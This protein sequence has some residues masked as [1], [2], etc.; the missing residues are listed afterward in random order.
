MRLAA[1][2]EAAS[3]A[4]AAAT[5]VTEL[6]EPNR[7][8]YARDLPMSRPVSRGS[9]DGAT[10]STDSAP[11]LPMKIWTPPASRGVA[12]WTILISLVALP[13]VVRGQAE[14]PSRPLMLS[15]PGLSWALELAAPGFVVETDRASADGRGRYL[16]AA[17]PHADL[18]LSVHLAWENTY[19]HVRPHQALG[20]LTP[21]ECLAHHGSRGPASQMS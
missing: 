21:A 5:V 8:P 14:P 12:I 1:F 10:V 15:L 4:E 6:P 7:P 17:N 19:N 18:V 11:N 13:T 9:R 20:Y 16:Y 3:P 2:A